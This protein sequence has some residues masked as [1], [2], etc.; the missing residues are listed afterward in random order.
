MF[1]GG[2][3]KKTGGQKRGAYV[4]EQGK[5][6]TKASERDKTLWVLQDRSPSSATPLGTVM[7]LE[8]RISK[9]LSTVNYLALAVLF[10]IPPLGHFPTSFVED[11]G[12][13]GDFLKE[14]SI[15]QHH[16]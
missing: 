13:G 5:E 3:N 16:K 12:V 14:A 1:V 8:G 2:I 7:A 6:L 11:S 15:V 4:L 10:I 9:D